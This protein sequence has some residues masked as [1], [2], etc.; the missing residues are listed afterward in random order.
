M[1]VR[2]TY[3]VMVSNS[4]YNIFSHEGRR[5]VARLAELQHH[6]GLHFDTTVYPSA[7]G[8]VDCAREVAQEFRLLATIVKNPIEVISLHNPRRD[9]I[10]RPAPAGHPPHTYEPRF[11]A[12]L[13]YVADSGGS[14][15][16]GSPFERDEFKS[17]TAMHLLTHPIWW[18]HD[19]PT[20]EPVSTLARF[21]AGQ[22]AGVRE[23]L[24]RDFRDYRQYL[25]EKVVSTKKL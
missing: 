5:L 11:F 16:Y 4:Y 1:D 19:E 14:W 9:L 12:D 10:N 2:A 22:V 13:A 17:G 25:E 6:I 23:M 15:R 24:A 3:F 20:G 7:E 8:L 18:A 21:A